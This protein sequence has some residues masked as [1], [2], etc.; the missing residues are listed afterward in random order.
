MATDQL[1]QEILDDS[2]Y[3]SRKFF[4][5]LFGCAL[6]LDMFWLCGS[7]AIMSG[8]FPIAVGA[9]VSLVGLYFG[10]N[11]MHARESI[12]NVVHDQ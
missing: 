6:I 5:V 12:K 7:S 1:R 10:V 9:I 4:L 8:I 3:R 2:G 11:F